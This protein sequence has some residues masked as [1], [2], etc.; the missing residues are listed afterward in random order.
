[1]DFLRFPTYFDSLFVV[2]RKMVVGA[3]FLTADGE[4]LIAMESSRNLY[5]ALLPKWI[6]RGFYTIIV[7]LSL[8]H[9]ELILND[10]NADSC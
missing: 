10:G 5:G 2:S 3:V 7:V 4:G 8:S 1:M 9:S 6:M